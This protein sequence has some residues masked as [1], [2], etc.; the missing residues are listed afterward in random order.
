VFFGTYIYQFLTL[1]SNHF[2]RD[3][4]TLILYV[5][6]GFELHLTRSVEIRMWH[7]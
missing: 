2:D 1:N 4:W 6:M 3:A 7:L 5:L